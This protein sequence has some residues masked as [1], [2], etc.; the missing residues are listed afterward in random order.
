M[1][2]WEL[3]KLDDIVTFQ[4]GY[5][6]P[7]QTN[8]D[9]FDGDIKWLRA[10]DLNDS[11]VWDTTRK[12][13]NLGF[14]SAG[15]GAVLFKPNTIAISKSGT[16]GRL[17]ILKDFMCGNRA[18]INIEVDEE[19]ADLMFVFYSL[20]MA[21][22]EII[23]YAVGS[24]Q[25]NLYPSVLGKLEIPLP[26]I[27]I[28]KKISTILSSLDY[29][30]INNNDM[31][32]KSQEIINTLFRSWFIDFEPVKAKAE[33]KLPYGMNKE[34]AT[35]FPESFEDSVLGPVPT[36]WAVG[37]MEDVL[38]RKQDST[39]SGDHLSERNYVPIQKIDSKILTLKNWLPY[40]EAASSLI[41]FSKNDLLFGAM[42]PYFHKVTIAP[43]DGVTR[44]TCFVFTPKVPG[45]L[46]FSLCLLNLESTI[47]Y[48]T[49]SSLGSTM[50]YAIWKN[51]LARHK[52][53][54]PPPQVMV[55]FS[56][57][58]AP[59]IENIRDGGLEVRKLSSTSDVL[60]PRLMSG[61]LEI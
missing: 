13:S 60:L 2:S 30:N 24:V 21:R 33:G 23:Q 22:R 17:G 14:E 52:I 35:L 61:E 6:N 27:P 49:D 7:S 3:V 53:V 16:I 56:E 42:R 26:S 36:G 11:E 41:L 25:A 20:M 44:S 57:L 31:S 45:T 8:N 46:G 19:K 29:S 4:E 59:L 28:Q 47:R 38:S 43:F 39:T 32:L 18:V 34:T 51:G 12:I 50:P 40:N 5:V 9:Y 37:M 54:L 58:I 55:A 48:A 15:K 1:A 10:V